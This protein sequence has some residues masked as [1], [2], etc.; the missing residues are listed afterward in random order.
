MAKNQVFEAAETYLG[1]KATVSTERVKASKSHDHKKLSF[2]IDRGEEVSD[3]F[4]GITVKWKL[5]CIQEDGS[6]IRHN[7]M[8]T[9]SVSEIRSYELT[10]HKKHKNTIFDSYFPY[11]MEIA[12]QI[13]QGNMAIKILSTE[14]GCWSHEPVKFNHPMSFNTLAIDIELRRE[15]M[16][17]LDNF[18]KAKE[19]YR[20]TGKAWQRGYLLYGPPGTGKSSLIAAMANYLNYDIFDLDL[21]DV[22][23]NKSLKQLIIGMSNRSILVIEDIDCTINLQNREEDENE[24]VVDN[25]YNKMTLSGLLNAVDGLW[26]CCGEEHIIVVTTNH[27][28]RLDPALLRPGRMDKQIHLSYCNFSAFKQLVINYLCITQH[29]LFEKIELLL[30][31]VQVT[32]AE[33]AEELTKDVDATECLQDLIKSLQAKKIMKEEIKNEENIKEEHELGS[34]EARTLTRTPTR[35]PDMTLT[36]TRRRHQRGF[37]PGLRGGHRTRT[38]RHS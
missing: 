10:F 4:E 13:K 23:D 31:E 11:V 9:S 34:Y 1:T 20:R 30:G 35:T 14:H 21:T 26:S 6:R 33:I 7:D 38:R 22:G 15:I 37:R 16:N 19:F 8:Y 24:E 28:E 29:E 25:G 32:P 12:K 27:K 17:D 36:R 2:N 3:D 5:I 18:V